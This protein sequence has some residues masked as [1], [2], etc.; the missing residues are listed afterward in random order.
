MTSETTTPQ[1]T[2]TVLVVGAGIAGLCCA[3][4]LGRT[5]RQVLTITYRPQ[6]GM[7]A[8]AAKPAS[9]ASAGLE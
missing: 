3:L 6:Y 7:T 8:R 5:D 4:S 1:T 2:E 9:V